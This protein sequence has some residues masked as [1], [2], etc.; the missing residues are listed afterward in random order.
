M[1][2]KLTKTTVLSA[3]VVMLL[4]VVLSQ[5]IGS[6][7]DDSAL[8]KRTVNSISQGL[9]N[10]QNI[11]ADANNITEDRFNQMAVEQQRIKQQMELLQSN[12][13]NS[14]NEIK[15]LIAGL[16]Q[17]Q[18]EQAVAIESTVKEEPA[19]QD[20]Q[21]QKAKRDERFLG[22]TNQVLSQDF[23]PNWSE[24]A[25]QEIYNVSQEEMF[26]G[27][28]VVVAECRSTHCLVNVDHD[29]QQS[30]ENFINSFPSK[31]G[32]SQSSGEIQVVDEGGQLQTRFVITRSG[33]EM[34]GKKGT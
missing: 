14:L 27:S 11:I 19:V 8:S 34:D 17:A 7:K 25:N 21:V 4:V 33:Y 13:E 2:I 26:K 3:I 1:T 23:D 6:K 5:V 20:P 32:W 12:T 18:P 30:M 31:L 22:L 15:D 16:S 10:D 9:K 29:D 24:G 28:H